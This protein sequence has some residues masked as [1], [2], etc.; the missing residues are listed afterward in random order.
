VHWVTL[1]AWC[2]GWHC[3]L[4]EIGG[5]VHQ[6]TRR[7]LCWSLLKISLVPVT[8]T[9]WVLNRSDGAFTLASNG[10]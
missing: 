7:S 6:V 10:T 3:A 4:G 9:N 1:A 2:I 8:L 5:M